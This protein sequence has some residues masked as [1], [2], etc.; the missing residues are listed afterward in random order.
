MKIT[1]LVCLALLALMASNGALAEWI[2]KE[3][4]W[5]SHQCDDL[6]RIRDGVETLEKCQK[7]CLDFNGPDNKKCTALNYQ[8]KKN[9][10]QFDDCILRSC[11]YPPPEPANTQSNYKGYYWSKQNQ[12]P[13]QEVTSTESTTTTKTIFEP[14]GEDVNW[15]SPRYNTGSP[16]QR[17]ALSEDDKLNGIMRNGTVMV[18]THWDAEWQGICSYGMFTTTYNSFWDKTYTRP[19]PRG[20]NFGRVICKTLGYSHWSVLH[21]YSEFGSVNG[22]LATN[23]VNCRSDDTALLD[24]EFWPHPEAKEAKETCSDKTMMGVTCVR[25]RAPENRAP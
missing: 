13:P 10:D 4:L 19:T 20:R 1:H 25:A 5:G 12:P 7:K 18:K 3:K 21:Y 11:D 15:A 24:C 16:G 2:E 23:E 17:L 8:Y 14:K 22:G 9:D 6:G